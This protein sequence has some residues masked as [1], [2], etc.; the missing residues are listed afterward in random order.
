MRT[1][2]LARELVVKDSRIKSQ[3]LKRGVG[4]EVVRLAAAD[5]IIDRNGPSVSDVLSAPPLEM[6]VGLKEI[7]YRLS[8][9]AGLGRK[10][11]VLSLHAEVT[12]VPPRSHDAAAMAQWR[13]GGGTVEIRSL[14]VRHGPLEVD[15]DGTIALDENLQPLAAFSLGVRGF[16][17]AV[18][19]LKAAGVIKPRRAVILK[20]VLAM[21]A[22]GK[23]DAK[24]DARG[25]RL[26]VP[27]SIQDEIIYIGPLVVGRVPP[28]HWPAGN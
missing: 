3:L 17:E 2:V 22:G 10:T 6:R 14:N 1:V 21:L 23:G 7:S 12:G 11:E 18:D 9:V 24:E 15:G 27:L 4:E 13:D 8:P 26:K 28:L 20:T 19:G 16:M 5:I 25:K